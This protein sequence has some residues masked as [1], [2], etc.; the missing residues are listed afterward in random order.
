MQNTID[1]DTLEAQ[2]LAYIGGEM[3]SSKI[4]ASLT[5]DVEKQIII[6]ERIAECDREW[7]AYSV[8]EEGPT[9]E[10]DRELDGI[11]SY[12]MDDIESL[13]SSNI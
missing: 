9:L 13:L 8:D 7:R 6:E 4:S 5:E 2:I 1:R 12:A 10:Q 11:I 3:T